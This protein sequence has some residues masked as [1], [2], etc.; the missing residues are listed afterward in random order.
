MP[1]RSRKNVK[2]TAD[3]EFVKVGDVIGL[4]SGGNGVAVL[5]DGSVVTVRQRY[6]VQHEGLHIIDGVEYLAESK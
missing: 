6:T 3:G 5:P 1:P 4:E 2:D